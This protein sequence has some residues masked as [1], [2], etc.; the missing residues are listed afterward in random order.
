MGSGYLYKW[1]GLELPMEIFFV[2][3]SRLNDV[4]IE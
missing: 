1:E 2:K 3:F 4:F